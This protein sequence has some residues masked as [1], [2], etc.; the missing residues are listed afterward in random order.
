[1]S[2]PDDR[3]R[4]V[5]PRSRHK[6]DRRLCPL[7][8]IL[9]ASGNS[10]E[11]VAELV[12]VAIEDGTFGDAE[13]QPLI[14][15]DVRFLYGRHYDQGKNYLGAS[16]VGVLNT[17]AHT[18]GHPRQAD[19]AMFLARGTGAMRDVKTI[20]DERQGDAVGLSKEEVEQMVL[21]YVL[22]SRT[23]VKEPA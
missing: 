20:R 7:I 10:E 19:C 16:A 3:G 1:M 13:M 12:N 18:H 4:A 6:Y 8:R 2:N 22:R 23:P 14:E 5:V 17:I 9:A 21:K 15:S 11:V